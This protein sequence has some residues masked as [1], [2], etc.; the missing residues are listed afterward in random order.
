MRRECRERFPHCRGLAILKCITARTW[1]TCR[2]ACW[3]HYI[4]RFP[5]KSVAGKTVPAFSTHAQSVILRIW[6]E[7]H[8]HGSNHVVIFLVTDFAK[9]DLSCIIVMI[10]WKMWLFCHI[11]QPSPQSSI[12]WQWLLV[13]LPVSINQLIVEGLLMP[14]GSINSGVWLDD[15]TFKPCMEFGK[16]ICT[17]TPEKTWFHKH[18]Q[19]R[20]C[21]SV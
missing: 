7:A 5:L 13:R 4:K 1:R 12:S 11:L 17:N 8:A 10:C 18:T 14:N 21:V 20:V 16:H 3:D 2:D 6:H 15:I 9:N 19:T